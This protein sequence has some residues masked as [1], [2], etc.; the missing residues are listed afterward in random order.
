MR[1]ARTAATAPTEEHNRQLARHRP[2]HGGGSAHFWGPPRCVRARADPYREDDGENGV[3]GPIRSELCAG[4]GL[5]CPEVQ[6]R[7]GLRARR[8]CAGGGPR[9]TS[10]GH[11]GLG[12]RRC[13]GHGHRRRC[14]RLGV[15]RAL[16]CCLRPGA[17]GF[18]LRSLDPDRRRRRRRRGAVRGC[19]N[20]WYSRL[21]WW[22]GLG[23][24]D[25]RQRGGTTST[26][27]TACRVRGDLASPWWTSGSEMPREGFI[28]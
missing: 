4:A 9:S 20:G 21:S 22:R 27:A 17:C 5:G 7:Q 12:G 10:T 23:L 19:Y 18:H 25:L 28:F 11:S 3:G 15:R 6:H 13:R 16:G 8:R 2:G 26:A 24:Q 14:H 1:V